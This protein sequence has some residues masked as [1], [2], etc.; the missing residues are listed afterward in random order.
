MSADLGALARTHSKT[1][2]GKLRA[3]PAGG[4]KN[5]LGPTFERPPGGLVH[6]RRLAGPLERLDLGA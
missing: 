2:A 5:L 3:K 6:L 4:L 1:G